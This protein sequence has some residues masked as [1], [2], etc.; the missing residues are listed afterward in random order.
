MKRRG[1]T[2]V[3]A[4]L[5]AIA[6]TA[7]VLVYVNHANSRALAGQRAVTVIVAKQGI[8]SGT[9]AGDALRMGMLGTEALPASSVPDNVLTQ[10]NADNSALVTDAAVAPGQVLTDAMLVT[11]NQ[12]TTGLAVPKGMVAVS[13]Q[14]CV[15]EAVGGNLAP[16]ANVMVFSTTAS[17]TNGSKAS[18]TGQ[19]GCT[20]N[21]HNVVASVTAKTQMLLPKVLVLAV[22]Q[23]TG[24]GTATTS[25]SGTSTVTNVDLVTLAVT[26]DDAAKLIALSEAGMPYLALVSP[27]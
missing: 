8:P 1:L 6:G 9:A 26:Q 16:G 12:A 10:V 20:A 7:G 24:T 18:L 23:G 3:L 25:A 15:P 11:A 13:I 4:V 5:L 17:S 14:F 22:G 21:Y 2:V 27:N 19:Y